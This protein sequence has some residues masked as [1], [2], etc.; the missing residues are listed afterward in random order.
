M[1]I[2]HCFVDFVIC[3]ELTDTTQL[4]FRALL[5]TLIV[6]QTRHMLR[7]IAN[8]YNMYM[9]KTTKVT[10]AWAQVLFSNIQKV[11]QQPSRFTGRQGRYRTVW[12]IHSV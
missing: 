10:I 4:I 8:C 1:S 9:H 11:F 5:D 7:R 6:E 12:G 3:T 2:W